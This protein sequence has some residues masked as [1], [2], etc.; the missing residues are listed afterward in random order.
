MKFR[1]I[2]S[3]NAVPKGLSAYIV[4]KYEKVLHV[5]VAIPTVVY[6][7]NSPKSWAVATVPLQCNEPAYVTHLK[8]GLL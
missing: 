4:C 5:I 2:T 1:Y 8:I 3:N 7:R 6:Y